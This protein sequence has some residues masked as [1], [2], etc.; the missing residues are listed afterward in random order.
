MLF[1]RSKSRKRKGE[2][3]TLSLTKKETIP[4]THSTKKNV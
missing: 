3:E 4:M 2:E 1:C